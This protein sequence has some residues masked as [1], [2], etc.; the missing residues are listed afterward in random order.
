[1]TISS[2]NT[3][4]ET[5]ANELRSRGTWLVVFEAS[6]SIIISLSACV[7]NVFILLVVYRNPR[8]RDPSNFYI[9]SLALSDVFIGAAAM[10]LTCSSVL[11]GQWV[12]GSSA[13]W[14]QA[15]LATMLGSTSLI[16]LT[17]VSVNRYF[18][19]VQPN[20][21]RNL[22]SSRSIAAS[23]VVSWCATA[24]VPLS[25]YL[26]HANV[27]FHPGHEV[28]VFIFSTASQWLLAVITVFSAIL[29]YQIIFFCY[30]KIWRHIRHHNILMSNSQVNTEEVRLTYLLACVLGGFT[31]CFTPYSI[32]TMIDAFME[33]F[34]L[35]RQ[36][37]FFGT[38][39]IGLASCI[40]PV[41]YAARNKDFR[42]EFG[43]LIRLT[44]E[45]L[46]EP[47]PRG[48]MAQDIEL[49]DVNN[50]DFPR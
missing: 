15:S 38:V 28:C 34:S 26:D 9:I 47:L 23:V 35:P 12:L 39:M 2:Q 48:R 41:I 27:E 10:P 6:L 46:V 3:N 32:M 49:R 40:N 18:K 25:L 13:C 16:T 36:V 19:V 22:F 45:T 5:L 31:F 42:R 11:A 29:P 30:Y 14:F 1:M 17:L 43:K 20:K 33:Q 21:Y 44:K 8:L 4:L 37:Y 50:R 24:A 7:G